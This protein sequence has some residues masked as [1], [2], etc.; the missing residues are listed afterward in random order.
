MSARTKNGIGLRAEWEKLGLGLNSSG[1]YVLPSFDSAELQRNQTMDFRMVKFGDEDC[2]VVTRG[3]YGSLA[4]L[5]RVSEDK[6]FVRYFGGKFVSL[7]LIQGEIFSKREFV[8]GLSGNRTLHV[9]KA[10]NGKDY[11]GVLHGDRE[12]SY[13]TLV[14]PSGSGFSLLDL[15]ENPP[16]QASAMLVRIES[17]DSPDALAAK[18]AL[19]KNFS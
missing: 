13:K 9:V 5:A 17:E 11:F 15:E 4:R 1:S 2:V 14:F 19:L 6:K 10:V 7:A 16:P 12:A 3:K 8:Q 18:D